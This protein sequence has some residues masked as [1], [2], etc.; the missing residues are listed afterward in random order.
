MGTDT[1]TDTVTGVMDM[2][3]MEDM[4]DLADTGTDMVMVAT[5][6]VD[7]DMATDIEQLIVN[8]KIR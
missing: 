2:G 7:T 6:T 4:V 5:D 3:D 8:I 1:D